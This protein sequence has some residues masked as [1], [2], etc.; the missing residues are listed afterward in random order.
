MQDLHWKLKFLLML[1]LL[2]SFNIRRGHRAGFHSK[3]G[4]IICGNLISYIHTKHNQNK[5]EEPPICHGTD[6][7]FT[8]P[9][10]WFQQP[11]E[12][13]AGFRKL[14]QQF[15]LVAPPLSSNS[16]SNFICFT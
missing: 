15:S 16:Q 14:F 8:S 7:H 10:L 6:K 5:K 12:P 11:G 13:S 2:L 9:N 4:H 3:L 1:L